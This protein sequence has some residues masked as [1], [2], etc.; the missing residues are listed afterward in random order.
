MNDKNK[1]SFSFSLDPISPSIK[2]T[3]FGGSYNY[4]LIEVPETELKKPEIEIWLGNML[5]EF[6]KDS[7]TYDYEIKTVKFSKWKF[8]QKHRVRFY[9]FY[10]PEDLV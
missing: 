9:K 1:N 4:F 2:I 3:D 7:W 8:W 6:Q 5:E 10:F